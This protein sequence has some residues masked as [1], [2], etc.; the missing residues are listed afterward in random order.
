MRFLLLFLQQLFRIFFIAI[1]Q[2]FLLLLQGLAIG[3]VKIL[4]VLVPALDG[5]VI[6]ED[7]EPAVLVGPI[8]VLSMKHFAVVVSGL[9]LEVDGIVMPR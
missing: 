3:L 9:L 5:L 8:E 2:V 4:L 7:V 1:A 6:E